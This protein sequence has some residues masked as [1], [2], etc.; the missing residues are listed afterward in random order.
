[1]PESDGVLYDSKPVP[2]IIC[3]ACKKA[4]C[5]RLQVWES[6]DGAYDDEKYTCQCGNTWWTD[7]IDS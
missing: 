2:D 7:G 5:V 1:V 6:S 4:G 3:P